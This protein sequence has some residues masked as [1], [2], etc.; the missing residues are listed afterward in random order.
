V[1]TYGDHI[2]TCSNKK[3]HAFF[4]TVRHIALVHC[5]TD[6]AKAAGIYHK[7]EPQHTFIDYQHR[8]NTT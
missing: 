7:V 5:I 1:D 2:L 3:N 4:T 6:M 8:N